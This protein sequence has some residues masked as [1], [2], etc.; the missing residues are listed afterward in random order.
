[1][2]ITTIATFTFFTVLAFGQNPKLKNVRNTAQA[3]KFIKANPQL[4]GELFTF[5]TEK[6]S[7][8]LVKKIVAQP[9]KEPVTSNGFTYKVIERKKSLSMRTSMIYLDGVKLTKEQITEIRKTIFAKYNAGTAFTE[10]AKEYT[11]DGNPN[12]DLGWFSE[13]MMFKEFWAGVKNRK[14]GELFSLDIPRKRWYYVILKTHDNRE[15]ISCTVLKIKAS[16]NDSGNVDIN[17]SGLN[18]ANQPM[19]DPYFVLSNDTVSTQGPKSITRNILRD[20]K[21]RLWFASWQGIICY[22]GKLFTNFT[23]KEGLLP[24]HVYSLLEDKTGKLWFGT[25]GGGIYCYDGTT[26]KLFNTSN[27]LSDNSIMCLMEDRQGNIW[28]GTRYGLSRYNAG[29]NPGFTNFTTWD[30]L[31][32]NAV[33][34]LIEDKSGMIWIGTEFGVNRYDGKSIT[35]FTNEKALPFSNVRAM[36]ADSKGNIWIAGQDG[37][38]RYDGSSQHFLSTDF[39]TYLFE[40]KNGKI[41]LSSGETGTNKMNLF[42]MDESSSSKIA[43]E[44]QVFGIAEDQAG[45]IWFGTDKGICRYDISLSP[46]EKSA[47]T[48]F[49]E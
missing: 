25:I 11:M 35:H 17:Q 23:L 49:R 21:G 40:D 12:C 3:E 5:T 19:V 42:R 29:A 43:C 30:G 18:A 45:N 34:S 37:L 26:F 9:G 27:G 15:I 8:D 20:K 10:L 28:I 7:S 24:F 46:E 47:F 33:Y 31:Q 41:W 32:S 44:T 16:A 22:D 4:A 36:L 6:D 13:E 39:T 48:F 2:K 1:M 14:K 38:C